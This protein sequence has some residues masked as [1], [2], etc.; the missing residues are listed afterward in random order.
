MP[1]YD[2]MAKELGKLISDINPYTDNSLPERGTLT[3]AMDIYTGAPDG[4][5]KPGDPPSRSQ[6]R[7]E[8]DT[9]YQGEWIFKGQPHRIG[10]SVRIRYRFPVLDAP[11]GK[12]IYW[13]EDYLLLGFE[14]S[15][16]G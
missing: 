6:V 1:M 4:S 11:G 7:L 13:A 9:K 14:G 2:D 12:V 16:S 8:T 3:G 5:V 15:N 10:K